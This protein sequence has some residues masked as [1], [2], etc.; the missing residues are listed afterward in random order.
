[1]AAKGLFDGLPDAAPS[2][3]D[4]A[5]KLAELQASITAQ[6]A[7][8]AN[9][10]AANGRAAEGSPGGAPDAKRM[11]LDLDSALGES[12][13]TTDDSALGESST[14]SDGGS[15]KSASGRSMFGELPP[16]AKP[17]GSP[18]AG[19]GRSPW[20]GT[21]WIG[22]KSPWGP[23]ST[24][25]G[26]DVV[27]S[28]GGH[29][30]DTGGS[31]MDMAD[32]PTPVEPAA[33]AACAVRRLRLKKSAAGFGINVNATATV[34]SFNAE[35]DGRPG[36]AQ[37]AGVLKGERIVEV[38]GVSVVDKAGLLLQLKKLK[39]QGADGL[40]FVRRPSLS[41]LRTRCLTAAVRRG[42]SRRRQLL[43]QR[44][45]QPSPPRPPRPKRRPVARPG[46]WT[47]GRSLARR[48]TT[49]SCWRRA[50]PA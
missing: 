5:R 27:T 22:G 43:A 3:A 34:L 29:G 20:V 11:K 28:P 25:G 16:P 35:P 26:E 7:A 14:T 44:R 47:S 23:R 50:P 4:K 17:K 33:P 46:P 6:M 15:A 13:T 10:S 19:D 41:C 40:E 12:S 31:M 30:V 48:R 45:P 1:M 21:P 8:V 42:C 39:A 2:A 32:P 36:P 49:T 9:G 38:N 24:E 37:A 18:N